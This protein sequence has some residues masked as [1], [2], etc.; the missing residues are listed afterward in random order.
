M[1]C[2]PPPLSSLVNLRDKTAIFRNSRTLAWWPALLGSLQNYIYFLIREDRI[3][4]GTSRHTKLLVWSP[5]DLQRCC[6]TTCNRT[7]VYWCGRLHVPGSKHCMG[8]VVKT[9]HGDSGQCSLLDCWPLLEDSD[10]YSYSM[11]KLRVVF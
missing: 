3:W 11:T 6:C 5:K 2:Y 8:T 1:T 9:L 10:K 4:R 7:E